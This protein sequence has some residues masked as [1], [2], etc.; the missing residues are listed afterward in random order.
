MHEEA[1]ELLDKYCNE[2]IRPANLPAIV[3][4][5]I[6]QWT[7]MAAKEWR[8]RPNLIPKLTPTPQ[9]KTMKVKVNDVHAKAYI[10]TINQLN[11][12][13]NMKLDTATLTTWLVEMFAKTFDIKRKTK[14][15]KI[16]FGKVVRK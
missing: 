11:E 4:R 2:N 1:L 14:D 16:Q 15:Y 5:I 6:E 10:R 7:Q 12:E 8:N 9:K 3:S 13:H